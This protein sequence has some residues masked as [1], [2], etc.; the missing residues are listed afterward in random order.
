MIR[1]SKLVNKYR[2]L[3]RLEKLGV[4]MLASFL[5]GPI[6]AVSLLLWLQWNESRYNECESA[7]LRVRL[8]FNG[9]PE[10]PMLLCDLDDS[11]R[12]LNYYMS[13][14]RF[15]EMSIEERQRN[16]RGFPL[17][18]SYKSVFPL[19]CFKTNEVEGRFVRVICF[20]DTTIDFKHTSG[21]VFNEMIHQ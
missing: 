18:F 15:M 7:F 16:N 12:Y 5:S 21:W 14:K 8:E 3:N 9:V 19:A 1:L 11:T 17:N 2:T 4:V 20:T 10:I 6:I 13:S